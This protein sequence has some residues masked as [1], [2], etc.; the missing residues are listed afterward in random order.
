MSLVMARSVIS[1]AHGPSW[2]LYA[3]QTM[4]VCTKNLDLDVVV[5]KSAKDRI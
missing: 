5:M 3:L 4:P 1:L 2:Q